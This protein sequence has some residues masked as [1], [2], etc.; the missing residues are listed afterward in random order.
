MKPTCRFFKLI[1]SCV[2]F[3]LAVS[4]YAFAQDELISHPSE[5]ISQTQGDGWGYNYE[6]MLIDLNK[7]KF[8]PYIQI[9]SIGASVQNRTIWLVTLTDKKIPDSLKYRVT[10]HVR[11]HPNEVQSF[12]ITRK[13][14]QILLS[15]LNFAEDFREKCIFNIVPMYNPDGVELGYARQNAHMVDLERNW[16]STTPEPE[17]KALKE[18]YIQFMT[19]DSPVKIALN[20]HGDGG[21]AKCYFV[22]HHQNGTSLEYAMLEQQFITG[23]RKYWP[24]GIAPWNSNVT[25]KD[26]IPTHFPESWWWRNHNKNVLALTHEQIADK[27]EETYYKSA[28]ALLHG[29]YDYLKIST[30]T[31]AGN[32]AYNISPQNFQLEQN[33]PN[34]FNPSTRIKYSL[35]EPAFV[36]LTVYDVLGNK[37]TSLVN[38]FQNTGNY[39]VIFNAGELSKT[40]YASG[41]LFYRFQ[42]GSFTSTKKMLLVK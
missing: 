37:I 8:N 14:I 29:I 13:V 17:V 40:A 11:T 34:P 31:D 18:L 32:I 23:V 19:S 1:I 41:M 26:S 4:S 36:T 35:A 10:M 3:L 42:A 39:S 5:T 16:E 7:W 21:A 22:Y 33:Y 12:Y 20:M 30:T 9:D 27:N 15:N 24:E 28:D 38:E 6:D 25:W 2:F